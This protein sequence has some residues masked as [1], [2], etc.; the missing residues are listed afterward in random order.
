MG[1]SSAIR[2]ATAAAVLALGLAGSGNPSASRDTPAKRQVVVAELFTSEGCSSCPPADALL[3]QLATDSPADSVEVLGLEEHVDYWDRLGW[4]DPFSSAVFTKRQSEYEA[5]VF[6]MGEV[7]TPQLI[8]GGSFQAVGS[9]AAAVRRA[10][11]GAAARPSMTVAV[12]SVVAGKQARIEVAVDIPPPLENRTRADIVVAIAETGLVSHVGG[13]ENRGRTLPHSAVVRSLAAIA[14]FASNASHA[15]ARADL[16]LGS[17]WR[18]P[19]LR[20]IA[21]VQDR[22]TLQIYGAGST[23]LIQDAGK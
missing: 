6:R 22:A 12:S 23:P 21:F 4:R 19:A 8:A 15:H 9:D 14:P 1:T 3:Q 16:P 2:R 17:G 13:G 5:R 11:A 18:I 10:V 20:A 7:Y